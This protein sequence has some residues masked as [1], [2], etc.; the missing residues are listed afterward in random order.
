MKKLSVFVILTILATVLLS[1]CSAAPLANQAP[2]AADSAASAAEPITL[3]YMLWDANQLPP[4]RACADEFTR[5]N[6]NITVTIDQF[7]WADYWKTLQTEFVTGSGP[8]VFTNQL[9]KYPE[10]VSKNQ[11]VDIQPFVDRDGVDTS[12]FLSG[13]TDLWVKEGKR[14]GLP[15]DWDTIANV[16]NSAML[17]QAG[18]TVDELDNATW[19][20]TDGGTFEQIIA[21]L[22]LDK[23]GN[24]GLSP[25]FDA[26]NV[27]QYGYV[28]GGLNASSG[29]TGW[30]NFAYSNGWKF[31][32]GPWST[33][34]YYDDP[35]LVETVDWIKRMMDK[36]FIPPYADALSLGNRAFFTAGDKVALTTDGSWT[37][38]WYKN[39]TPFD[40]GF[41][42]LPEGPMGRKSMFNGLADAIW[43]GG[44][45]QEES[46]QLLKFLA[47]EECQTIVGTAG[48]VF[49]ALQP[50]V[51]AAMETHTN[52]GLDVTAFTDLARPETTY[53]FPI[54][55]HASEVEPIINAAFDSIYLGQMPAADALAEANAKINALFQ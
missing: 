40:F 36:G 26:Q 20:P 2:T 37:I 39:N 6:P 35:K 5:L 30:G 46:W 29:N 12:A 16:Y 49:P 21:K 50:G 8:D 15:K 32:D 53:L 45:H 47:S 22:S 1:A 52:N 55:D 33:E 10:F 38:G 18:V 13:L 3:R 34:Y 25:D 23:N 43:A 14:Y 7:A 41:A 17:E 11:L 51:D 27:V 9:S 42:R 31:N 19:N 48:V 4:Y 28:I 44:K 54:A 24:N